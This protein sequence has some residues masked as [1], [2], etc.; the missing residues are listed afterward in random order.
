MYRGKDVTVGFGQPTFEMREL[1]RAAGL[2]VRNANNQYE[3]HMGIELLYLSE[4]CRRE[5]MGEGA[6]EV[7][8]IAAFVE[9][10]P[11]S[12]IGPFLDRVSEA[13][14]GGY[15]AGLLLVAQRVLE[16]HARLLAR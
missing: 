1:L 6:A 10:Y 9:R 5:A 13:V 12:W 4:L 14:P 15:F 7:A 3:D 2:E 11:L 8:D 16:H